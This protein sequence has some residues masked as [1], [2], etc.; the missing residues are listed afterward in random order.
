VSFLSLE[1]VRAFSSYF[2]FLCNT[3]VRLAK[4][5]DYFLVLGENDEKL[6]AYLKNY[7]TN[8]AKITPDEK[9]TK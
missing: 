8:L 5:G 2:L 6:F 4:S 1:N 3:D 7:G 9:K